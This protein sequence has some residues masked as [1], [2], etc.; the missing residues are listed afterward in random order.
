MM[1]RF[2]MLIALSSVYSFRQPFRR[3]LGFKCVG[4][5]RQRLARLT[6]L[7][8]S[9]EEK[10]W[11][12]FNKFHVGNWLGVQ[13]VHDYTDDDRI[14]RD[15]IERTRK[16]TGTSLRRIDEKTVEHSSMMIINKE[17]ERRKLATYSL[18][19]NMPKNSKF[20]ENVSIGGPS[21]DPKTQVSLRTS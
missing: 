1:L 5:A 4:M 12:L 8:E 10:Q 9:T 20:V 17:I 19:A 3:A 7:R 11:S 14:D 2:M 6:R 16:F 13:T 21:I 18:G 15:E